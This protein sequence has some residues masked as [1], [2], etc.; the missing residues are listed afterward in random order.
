MAVDKFNFYN[1]RK[2]RK[3]WHR[4]K[5]DR[6]AGREIM[7][8]C[9]SCHAE[10]IYIRTMN[11]KM[12]PVNAE[13]VRFTFRLGGKDKIVTGNGEILTGEIRDDGE[14]VGYV[15]HFSTCPD[16]DKWRKRR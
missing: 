1:K 10:I 7:A 12:T 13:P 11:G 6:T 9:R 8:N 2:R 5:K 15:S 14:E 3:L 16:A 4:R